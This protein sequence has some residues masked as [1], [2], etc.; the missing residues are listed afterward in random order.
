MKRIRWLSAPW[1]CRVS[2]PLRNDHDPLLFPD[3]LAIGAADVSF[4]PASRQRLPGS[5]ALS[6]P[7]GPDV[8]ANAGPLGLYRLDGW[9]V[10]SYD[11]YRGAILPA[12]A[13]AS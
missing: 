9:A 11:G 7:R 4:D 2:L 13:R 8:A 5:F 6:A 1:H 3:F 12:P 10:R